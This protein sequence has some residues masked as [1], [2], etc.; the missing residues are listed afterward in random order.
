M[1][2]ETDKTIQQIAE[3]LNFADQS[4]FTRYFRRIT[5]KAPSE[6]REVYWK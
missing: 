4:I 6:W 2:Y 5:G 3:E 1:L